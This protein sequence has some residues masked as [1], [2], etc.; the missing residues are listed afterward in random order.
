MYNSLA[1]FREGPRPSSPLPCNL[2][3][4][5][6]NH[7]SLSSVLTEG[8]EGLLHCMGGRAERLIRQ[9]GK[10]KKNGGRC[11]NRRGQRKMGGVGG[12]GRSNTLETISTFFLLSHFRLL[13]AVGGPDRSGHLLPRPLRA[14]R[15]A[16]PTAATTA[17]RRRRRRQQQQQQ[18]GGSKQ[19]SLIWK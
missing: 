1:L 10:W 6:R 18:S 17:Q 13:Y 16:G 4:Q 15:R 5:G 8:G 9:R 11:P 19:N 7:F 2:K 3:G 12:W 14:A